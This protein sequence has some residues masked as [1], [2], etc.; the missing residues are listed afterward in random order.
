[1][2]MPPCLFSLPMVETCSER[3]G[4]GSLEG[5]VCCWDIFFPGFTYRPISELVTAIG[6]GSL[7]SASL[8]FFSLV[9]LLP[10]E[11]G[12]YHSALR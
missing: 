2:M 3:K 10:R 9:V 12:W 6:M 4:L 5:T 11:A 7:S 8:L 1:M